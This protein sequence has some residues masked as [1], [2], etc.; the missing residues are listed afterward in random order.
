MEIGSNFIYRT[1]R[2]LMVGRDKPVLSDNEGAKPLPARG[3]RIE[4]RTNRQGEAQC[5]ERAGQGRT[6]QDSRAKRDRVVRRGRLARQAPEGS[7]T[8]TCCN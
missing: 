8:W 1:T 7:G 6:A 2:N 4:R 3:I 5:D